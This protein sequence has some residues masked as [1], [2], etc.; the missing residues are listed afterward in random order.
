[1]YSTRVARVSNSCCWGLTGVPGATVGATVLR[2]SCS[3][4]GS[5]ISGSLLDLLFAM[6]GDSLGVV[7]LGDTLVYA[8]RKRDTWESVVKCPG[9]FWVWTLRVGAMFGL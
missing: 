6:T 4:D 9:R 1:M 5:S 8:V 3:S 7:R 2:S